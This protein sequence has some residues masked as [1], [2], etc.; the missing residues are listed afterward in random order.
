ME[1]KAETRTIEFEKKIE[2][3][4]KVDSKRLSEEK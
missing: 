1:I 4:E 3:T 2:E